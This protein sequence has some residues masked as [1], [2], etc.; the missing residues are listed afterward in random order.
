MAAAPRLK[1]VCLS[2]CLSRARPSKRTAV[3]V[4]EANDGVGAAAA[5]AGLDDPTD[6]ILSQRILARAVGLS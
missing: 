3:R 2:V 4:G 1:P 5:P 6:L